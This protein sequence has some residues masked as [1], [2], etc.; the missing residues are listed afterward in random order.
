LADLRP[1]EEV[2]GGSKIFGSAL[3][4]SAHSV[5]VSLSAFSFSFYCYIL[6]LSS[7]S[8]LRIKLL[9]YNGLDFVDMFAADN[10]INL[11]TG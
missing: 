11:R 9:H 1:R 3:L 8:L 7:G 10:A 2:C 4:Q 5:C 6:L